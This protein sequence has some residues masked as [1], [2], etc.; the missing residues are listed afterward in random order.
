MAETWYT[1]YDLEEMGIFICDACDK[2]IVE[3]LVIVPSKVGERKHWNYHSSPTNC[4]NAPEQ[5]KDWVRHAK[6]PKAK[7]HN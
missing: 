5:R 2:P 4:A 3:G 1:K 7:A 6:A